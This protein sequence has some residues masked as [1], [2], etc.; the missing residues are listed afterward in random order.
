M[1]ASS[2]KALQEQESA[3][4]KSK[5]E[6]KPIELTSKE[7]FDIAISKKDFNAAMNA[8]RD[9]Q[10][11]NRTRDYLESHGRFLFL[12]GKFDEAK[13]ALKECL[14]TVPDSHSCLIDM[15]NTEL[16]IGTKG[17][18]T[19]AVNSCLAVRPNDP[20]CRNLEGMAKMN[21]GKYSDAIAIYQRLLKENGSYGIRFEE[22]S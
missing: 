1:P 20:Q 16:Q 13:V 19:Q 12:T 3:N 11:S 4:P 21:Q 18:Q 7:A 14:N 5:N 22:A 17:E 15:A 2:K 8:I 10:T 9:M 6:S